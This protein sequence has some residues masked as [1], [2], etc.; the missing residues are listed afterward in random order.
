M[1][2]GEAEADDDYMGDL[3]RFLPANAA[4]LAPPTEATPQPPRSKKPSE[5]RRMD[6]DRK[7]REEDERTMAGMGSA[8]PQSNVGFKLL[9]R[10]G[11]KPGGGLGRGGEGRAVPVV[12]EI[13]RTRA[14]LGSEDPE[15]ARER[16]ERETGERKR[17]R[18]EELRAEFGCRQRSQWRVRR[19]VSDFRKAQA[20]LA[21]LENRV[22]VEVVDGEG[23]EKGGNGGDDEEEEE[24][25]TEEVVTLFTTL[26]FA[27]LSLS[28]SE[29]C[30]IY[31]YCCMMSLFFFFFF[32]K[33]IISKLKL[34][35]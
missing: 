28:C 8:I 27:S 34:Q 15:A 10:M 4:L 1:A 11:Y 35:K 12:V 31:I 20:A 26:D 18:E 23:E 32:Q 33:E 21:Q 17:R 25:I 29:F 3:S 7:Q 13:R 6:K 5:R 22:E 19:V 2:D 14:G 9:Q 24:I 16:R 30:S